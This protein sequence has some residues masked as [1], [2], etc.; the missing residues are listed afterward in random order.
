[1]HSQKIPDNVKFSTSYNRQTFELIVHNAGYGAMV[2]EGGG[3]TVTAAVQSFGIPRLAEEAKPVIGPMI[4]DYN[5]LRYCI[6]GNGTLVLNDRTYSISPGQCYALMAGDVAYET[7]ADDNEPFVLA[8]VTL[9]GTRAPLYISRMGVSSKQPFFPI[10]DSGEVLAMF[11]KLAAAEYGTMNY[12]NTEFLRCSQAYAILQC[13]RDALA[14]GKHPMRSTEH[15]QEQYVSEALKY[16]D[17]NYAHK[18]TVSDIAAHIGINRSYFYSLFKQHTG[19]SPQE[20]LT[21]LRI[22]KACELFE[23]PN[24]TVVN[25]ANAL[26]LE[27]SVFFRH[28]KRVTGKTPSEYK[29]HIMKTKQQGG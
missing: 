11:E 16:M 25:V 10:E 6:S 17:S 2:S 18:I 28:F 13:L 1:M 27:S 22:S 8:F 24:S 26:N 7:Y 4:R 14:A 5:V 21:R 23:F 19:L 12:A 15:L 20:H 29:Q 9:L 3:H